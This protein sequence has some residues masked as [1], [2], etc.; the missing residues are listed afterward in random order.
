VR[1]D[2][3]GGMVTIATFLL[4]VAGSKAEAMRVSAE[5]DR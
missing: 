1:D 4:Q 5:V 2:I 3:T